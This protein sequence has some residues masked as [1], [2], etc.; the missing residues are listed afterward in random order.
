MKR[1]VL[2]YHLLTLTLS[3]AVLGQQK[4]WVSEGSFHLEQ[5]ELIWQHIY[6]YDGEADS[7][8]YLITQFL[9]G[10]YYTHHIIKSEAGFTGEIHH[11]K[12]DCKRLG[13][14]YLNTPRMYWSG[15][16]T[17]K[18]NV[19]IKGS[20]YRVSVF[21]L[22]FVNKPEPQ[23]HKTSRYPLKGLYIDIVTKKNRTAF[24]VNERLNIALMSVALHDEFNIR[25]AKDLVSLT[26]W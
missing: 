16:W 23:N 11:L 19:E 6:T 15:E 2:L 5:Q 4:D 17:G 26:D 7:L 18:F 3:T 9:R 12:L 25:N 13:R 22:H 20:R 21:H 10:K 1:H 24:K 8:E 14:T